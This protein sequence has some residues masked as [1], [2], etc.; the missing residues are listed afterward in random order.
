MFQADRNPGGLL[1]RQ[2]VMRARRL[3]LHHAADRVLD[4]MQVMRM[5][6]GHQSMAL[7]EVAA[8]PGPPAAAQLDRGLAVSG[9]SLAEDAETVIGV[10]GNSEAMTAMDID[11]LILVSIDDHVVEPPDMFLRHVP[12][13]YQD[14]APIVVTDARASTS[15]CIRAGRKASAASTPWCRGRPRN[16]AVTRP[17]FAEMR[18]ASTTCTS[19]SAT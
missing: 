9:K 4:L 19:G 16:G 18:P 11:D 12:K 3:D 15:G 8:G 7:V 13:K 6:A 2:Q 14:E 10:Q 5:P 1:R 17:G